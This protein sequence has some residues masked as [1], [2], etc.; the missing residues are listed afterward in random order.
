MNNRQSNNWEEFSLIEE[1]QFIEVL[2]HPEKQSFP[3]D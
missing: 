3:I 2:K 1:I